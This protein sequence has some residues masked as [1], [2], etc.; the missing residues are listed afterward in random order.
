MLIM[1]LRHLVPKLSLSK[2]TSAIVERDNGA[3]ERAHRPYQLF[4]TGSYTNTGGR[5]EGISVLVRAYVQ[6]CLE[7]ANLGYPLHRNSGSMI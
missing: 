3:V 2:T 1:L 5:V 7:L 6:L 4:V